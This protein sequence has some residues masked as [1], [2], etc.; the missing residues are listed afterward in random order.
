MI[1]ASV[2]AAQSEGFPRFRIGKQSS[3]TLVCAALQRLKWGLANMTELG[4]FFRVFFLEGSLAFG[5]PEVGH[6][7]LLN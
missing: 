5:T 6:N 1:K 4:C 2:S 3:T 7:L